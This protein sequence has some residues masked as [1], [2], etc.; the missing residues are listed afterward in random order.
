MQLAITVLGNNSG[1]VI[2][3]ILSAVSVCQCNI[4]ELRTSSLTRLVSGYLMV[5]GSWNHI[6]KLEV[7][8]EALRTRF[9]VQLSLLRPE[10]AETT[11]VPL[12]GVPY[13]LE[14]ISM[15]QKDLLFAVT[16][17]LLERGIYIEEIVASRHQAMFFS[18]QVFSSKFV[19]LVPADVRI[20]SL[21]EEFL[22]FCDSINIDAIL[23][24]IKR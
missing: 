15:E 11:I 8:L 6:A 20:M 22:D 2:A 16:S 1:D 4:I 5:D 3:E 23:E 19:L 14:T 7:M 17:F 24:P 18:N 21:R 13:N 10:E 12:E 9:N